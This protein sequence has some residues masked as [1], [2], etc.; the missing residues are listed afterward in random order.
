M[1][2]EAPKIIAVLAMYEDNSLEHAFIFDDIVPSAADIPQ[3]LVAKISAGEIESKIMSLAEAK[4]VRYVAFVVMSE[5][6]GSA[7]RLTEDL[8]RDHSSANVTPDF[9]QRVT[10]I[11]LDA[12]VNNN[13]T[14]GLTFTVYHPAS[15]TCFI[16]R[17]NVNDRAEPESIEDYG[18]TD[19]ARCKLSLHAEIVRQLKAGVIRA[20]LPEGEYIL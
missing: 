15:D 11:A 5:D 18:T 1:T 9:A 2:G 13:T 12:I 4:P 8:A 14:K 10:E 17:M 3:Q 19:P 6:S 20:Q 16:K 7:F